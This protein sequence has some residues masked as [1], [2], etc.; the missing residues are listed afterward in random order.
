MMSVIVMLAIVIDMLM[1]MLFVAVVMSTVVPVRGRD[2]DFAKHAR[3][4]VVQQ[5]AVI[6]PAPQR[7]R[8]HGVADALRGIHHHRVLANLECAVL[9]LDFA[10]HAVQG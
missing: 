4:H 1:I 10:P 2:M 5:M 3:F 7:I 9:V 6:G 8:G